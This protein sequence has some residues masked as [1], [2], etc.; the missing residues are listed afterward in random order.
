MT[1]EQQALL[2]K[3]HRALETAS[4]VL[5]DGDHDAAVNR[6]YYAAF[7]A[8]TAALLLVGETPK[9]HTGTHHRFR[10]HF[11][12]TG[13]LSAAPHDILERAYNLR[14]RADYEA[15]SLFDETGTRHLVADV[16]RFVRAVAAMIAAW[17]DQNPAP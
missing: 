15:L 10:H 12:T 13:R 7:Y 3:A 5:R 6:A 14:Q 2:A 9:T 4:I 8:A 1:P 11:V 16:E 17:P